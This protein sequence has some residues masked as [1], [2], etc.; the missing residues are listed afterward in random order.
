MEYE[1]EGVEGAESRSRRVTTMR[2]P[3]PASAE[4]LAALDPQRGEIEGAW[5]EWK[6]PRRGAKR[7]LRSQTPDLVRQEFYALRLAH[8]AVRGLRQEATLQ[9]DEDPDR[10]SFVHAVRVL[11]RQLCRSG[12]MP[13][14]GPAGVA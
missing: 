8:F 13:P 3:A 12:A 1:R 6:T 14:W 11:L 4:E 10:L 7:V 2:D 9:A 5:D